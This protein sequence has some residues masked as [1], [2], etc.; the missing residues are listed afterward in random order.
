MPLDIT[1]YV[2]ALDTNVINSQFNKHFNQG[3]TD[4]KFVITLLKDGQEKMVGASAKI[5]MILRYGIIGTQSTK[6][7]YVLQPTDSGYNITINS[8]KIEIP[9]TEKI[10]DAAGTTQMILK[11]DDTSTAYTYSML[12][13]IDENPAYTQQSTADNLPSYKQFEQKIT[14]LNQK[15]DTN[16]INI[17]T[18]TNELA[19]AKN[20]ITTIKQNVVDLNAKDSQHDTDINKLK[21]DVSSANTKIDTKANLDMSNVGKFATAQEG[22]MFYKKNNVLEIAP[23]NINDN[24]KTITTPYSLKVPP[25]TLKLGENVEIHE[26]GGFVENST[27]SLGKR[28]LMLDYEN[29]PDLGSKKPIYYQRGAKV[30]KHELQPEVGESITLSQYNLGTPADDHQTQ[31][32]YLNLI[33]PVTNLTLK[34]NINGKD[35]AYYPSKLAWDGKENGY[36]KGSGLQKFDIRP[37]WS[38]LKEYNIILSFKADSS[39]R[40]QGKNG[41]PYFAI[42]YNLITRKDMALMEDIKGSDTFK[43]LTDTPNDYSGQANKF[44]KVKS[45][46]SG[47]EFTASSGTVNI[48]GVSNDDF[49]KKGVQAG[50]LQQDLAD[51]DLDKLQEKGIAAKLIT[52]ITVGQTQTSQ[53]LLLQ[54]PLL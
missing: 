13:N 37:F 45:D 15:V 25:N 23:L 39:I 42:D 44:V 22:D 40:V 2:I 9:F 3:S 4:G 41:N 1:P 28:Y 51:V 18:N 34:V 31:A 12:Y 24:D 14:D 38:S 10:T 32:F 11:V 21:T 5:T 46:E 33:D 53:L 43:A 20:E 16:V 54:F 6:G 47:L 35:V 30:I 50:L 26:N 7:S 17:Q 27:L 52:G 36:S 48:D 49:L 19:N 29:D 8:G